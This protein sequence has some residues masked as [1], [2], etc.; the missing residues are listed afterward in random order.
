M[1]SPLGTRIVVI[2]NTSSGKSTLAARLAQ[3]L[4]VPFVELDA[5][6][7][8]PNWHSLAEHDPEEFERR[9]REATAGDGWVVAGSYS[10]FSERIFWP[11]LETVVWLDLPLRLVLWRVIRRSWKRWR[12]KELLWGTNRENFWKHWMVW[13]PDSLLYWAVTTHRR[14][15]ERYLRY[16]AEPRWAHIRW[17]RLTSPAEVEAFTHSVERALARSSEG[18]S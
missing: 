16:M 7:W 6:N 9:I 12:S 15:R 11:R 8:E 14:K 13:S 3:G 4:G 2:G 1:P 18:T 10:S 17:V 5:L